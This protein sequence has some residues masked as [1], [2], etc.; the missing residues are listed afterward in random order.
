MRA[1]LK[2][3]K[4]GMYFFMWRWLMSGSDEYCPHCDNHFVLEAKTPKASLQVEGE[5]VRKDARHVAPL[6]SDGILLTILQ[7]AQG[8]TCTSRRDAHHIRCQGSTGQVGLNQWDTATYSTMRST[9][10][11]PVGRGPSPKNITRRARGWTWKDTSWC[12]RLP[13]MSTSWSYLRY[14][15]S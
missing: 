9:S 12:A 10:Y 11:K 4:D 1:N 8:R 3:R 6:V 14:T 5:D 7:D 13:F 15:E 2:T